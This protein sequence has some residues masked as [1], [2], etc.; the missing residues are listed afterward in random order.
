MPHCAA[1]TDRKLRPEKWL[2]IASREAELKLV[3]RVQPRKINRVKSAIF[4]GGVCSSEYTGLAAITI[5]REEFS[6]FPFF[7]ASIEQLKKRKRCERRGWNKRTS[8]GVSMEKILEAAGRSKNRT[9][10][11]KSRQ[12]NRKN[13][14]RSSRRKKARAACRADRNSIQRRFFYG[15]EHEISKCANVPRFATIKSNRNRER[16]DWKQRRNI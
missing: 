16:E 9:S 10:S 13:D 4:P 3:K 8:E 7:L 5:P 14:P 6:F 1:S 15:L 2:R 12:K 11:T